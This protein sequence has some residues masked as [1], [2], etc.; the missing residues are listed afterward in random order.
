ML[1][2]KKINRSQTGKEEAIKSVTCE[3]S[4]RLN[5]NIPESLYIDLKI[6]AMKEKR[7]LNE[8]VVQWIKE[9]LDNE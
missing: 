4:K 1:K 6:K 9:Y 3:N 8:L 5:A 7:A 2:A